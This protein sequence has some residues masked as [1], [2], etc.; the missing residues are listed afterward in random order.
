MKTVHTFF[1]HFRTRVPQLLRKASVA[2][3]ILLVTF[4][5]FGGL[6][7][8]LGLTTPFAPTPVDAAYTGKQLRTIEYNLG[9]GSETTVRASTVLSYAGNS[10]NTVKATA[11]KKTITIEGSGIRVVNAYVDVSF[12][13]S[14]STN[15]VSEQVVF[16]AEYSGSAGS[17]VRVEEVAGNTPFI[18][19]GPSGYFR[20][21]HDVT[22]FFATTSDA[23]WNG[24]VGVVSGV[25]A[26]FSAASTRVLTTVKLVVTYE[27]DVSASA[28]SEVKTVRLPLDSANGTDTGSRQAACAAGATCAF[29]YDTRNL[30]DWTADADLLDVYVELHAKVDSA[31]PA[32]FYPQIVG[33]AAGPTYSSWEA[34]A[35]D[36]TM[37]V[38][39]RPAVGAPDFTQNTLQTLN[40]VN[41]AGTAPLSVLGGEVVVTYR[42]STGDAAQTETVRFY[43]DQD[44]ATPGTATNTFATIAPVISQSG[45]V[46]K[47]IWYRVH[48]SPYQAAAFTIGGQV[49]TST[50]KYNSYTLT[51]T[52]VRAGDT[53]TIIYDMSADAANYWNNTTTI[54]GES[55]ST[56]T[57]GPVAVELFVTFTW[58]GDAASA[59]TKS[60]TYS[61]AQQGTNSTA[62]TG[63]NRPVFVELPETVTKT[64][65]SSYLFTNYT[66]SNA[67]TITVG[68]VTIGVN[69]STTVITKLGDT[70]AYTSRYVLRVASSTLSG[71]D[72]IPWTTRALEIN[73]TR[74]Q[75]NVAYFGNEVVI[76]YDAALGENDPVAPSKKQLRTVEYVLGASTD[77][78][79]RASAAT[80]WAGSTWGTTKAGG[81][82]RPIV[83][84]GSNIRVVNA[85]LETS[86][87]TTLSGN[88]TLEN[89]YLDVEGS[90]S[91]GTDVPVGEVVGASIFSTTGLTGHIRGMHDVTALFDRQS[92]AQW[93]AGIDVVGAFN[94]TMSAGNRSLTS[95]KL[96]ITYESDYSLVSHN[97]VKT[98]RF[99][100]DSNSGADRGTRTTTCT[101]G[102]ICSFAYTTTIPDAVADADILDVHF[103]MHAEVNSNIASAFDFQIVGMPTPSNTFPWTEAIADD[104]TVEVL[105]QPPIG[106]AGFQRN[107][108]QQLNIGNGTAP[109]TMLGGE[110]VVTY[111]FSTGATEQAETVSYFLNQNATNPGATRTN[112]ATITPTILNGE[113]VVKNIWYKVRTAPSAATTLILNGR[114]GTSTNVRSNTYTFT[115]LNRA[116]QTPT[117]IQDFS[118]DVGYFSA[119]TTTLEGSAIFNTAASAYPVGAEA[120]VSFVWN[121]SLGG[122][123]T[124]S[125]LFSAAQQGVTN[126]ANT[127]VNRSLRV[128]LPEEVTKTFRSAYLKVNHL[129]SNAAT[130]ITAGTVVSMSENGITSTVTENGDTEAFNTTYFNTIA[131]STFS[132]GNTIPWQTKYFEIGEKKSVANYSYFSNTMVVTYDAAQEYKV[133][134]FTQNYFRVYASSTALIPTDPWPAGAVDLGENTQVTAANAPPGNGDSLRLRMSLQ[135][136]TT[137]MLASSTAFALQYAPRVSTCGAIGFGSW[138]TLG[139]PGSGSTWRGVNTTPVD[140][141]NL[142][143]STP[144]P[145]QLV[146]S[147]SDRAGTYGESVPTPVNPFATAVGEDVEYDWNIENNGAATDTPYCFRMTKSDGSAFYDYAFYPT[148]RT[149]G[150]TAKTDS[151]RWYDD[152]TNETPSVPL[153]NEDA[154]PVDVANGNIIK[155]RI[156]VREVAGSNGVNQKF[157]V[158]YS[159]WADFSLGVYDVVATSSCTVNSI[160]C[161][162]DGVDDDDDS[163]TA[164]KLTT[165]AALGRHNEAATTT[166]T[167]Y[168]LANTATEFEYTLKHAGARVNTVYF[169]RLWDNNH[170]R[171]V[172]LYGGASYPSL[173]TQGALLSTTIAG[174]ASSTVTE[175]VTTD[176]DT[177]ATSIAFGNVPIGTAGVV[178]AQ[179]MTISTNAT[180]G[181]QVFLRSNDS[182]RSSY[183]NTIPDVS[184]SNAT[185]T[186]W[187]SGCL[188][189][190]S[191]CWG[192]H[193]GDDTLSGGSTRFLV[194]DTY[195][196]LASTTAEEIIS[197]SGPVTNE[198]TDIIFRLEAHESQVAGQ[199]TTQLQYIV[200]PIF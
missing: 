179:Q 38:T 86:Y 111:R 72:T 55:R 199:Y 34:F 83:L 152:E 93:A 61:G 87:Y 75:N 99:P 159:E 44:P 8:Y 124:R 33:G 7:L 107:V 97:E 76:T 195:A 134:T 185:P 122:T 27:Q 43:V 26:T 140:G 39:Y 113:K 62:N 42:Y 89:V 67:N 138:S 136:A 4:S 12:I 128:E 176:V 66:H 114:I 85:F 173:A 157:K 41:S 164:L 45:R 168:P 11:G 77:A 78:T 155:L 110:I 5:S 35:D 144:A 160:W 166:S 68:T 10:W 79:A 193:S 116:G 127:W 191:G 129:H 31:L 105:Y 64:Y 19:S 14:T 49:G 183:G 51:A 178:A 22:A 150:Y 149:A 131:S 50:K 181:Y 20:G 32:V 25:A 189:G 98:V 71:G 184:G 15:L 151:W 192:Y 143:T 141:T 30:P 9:N 198:V 3:L 52:N 170:D 74:N 40:I 132:G 108:T 60:V 177:D 54:A 146:L 163:L 171:P 147:V 16:D 95:M 175:G 21:T 119:A 182:M 102:A 186:A 1:S 90:S 37:N 24:G 130:T 13:I 187:L 70:E 188:S 120:Y 118:E 18:G 156:N 6:D 57:N 165:T 123:T 56:L 172:D 142:S 46:A 180:E 139:A 194:D 91:S 167:A 92:D 101:S 196:N 133:P 81:G 148:I 153:A 200:V 59:V 73:E 94:A 29:T 174:V 84:A 17:D 109:L 158:Q 63:F 28:H 137:T 103:D 36:A 48:S 145:G 106:G 154:V 197:N 112:F 169:F 65:R 126:V 2:L 88:T 100:L 125:V 80:T 190:A 161:Y 69:A 53:P 104:N 96:Y 135:V 121:G 47:H 115:A 82:V 58:D 23:Q 117:I 162:G